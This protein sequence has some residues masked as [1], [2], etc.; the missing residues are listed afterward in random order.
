MPDEAEVPQPPPM[1]PSSSSDLFGIEDPTFL[2]ALSTTALPGE[3]DKFQHDATV[4]TK[5]SSE[6]STQAAES[7][8]RKRSISSEGASPAFTHIINTPGSQT[9]PSY[10]DSDIYGPSKFQGFGEYMY[11]KRAKLSIQNSEIENSNDEKPSTLFQGLALYV[12]NFVVHV[13]AN[14]DSSVR[15]TAKRILLFKNYAS[16]SCNMV[17]SSTLTSIGK[18]WCML[19]YSSALFNCSSQSQFVNTGLTLL[20]QTSRH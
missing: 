4:P 16:S 3:V 14:V 10:T 11:R 6:Y 17:V 7:R 1:E 2:E 15:S 20:R 18:R 5:L 8:K 9:Q 13:C 12:R 19:F